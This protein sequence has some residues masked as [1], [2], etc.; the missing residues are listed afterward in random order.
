VIVGSAV[1]VWLP[2]AVA[3]VTAMLLICLACVWT[4]RA[5]RWRPDDDSESDEGGGSARRPPPNPP[6]PTGPVSWPEFERQ[7]AAYVDHGRPR[8][9]T[10]APD[11]SSCGAPAGV[12]RRP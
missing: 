5:N 4:A 3:L 9:V 12:G 7:F 8:S 10:A 6:L 11:D 2:T 1:A